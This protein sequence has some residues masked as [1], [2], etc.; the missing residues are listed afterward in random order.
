MERIT[1]ESWQCSGCNKKYPEVKPYAQTI[2]GVRYFRSLCKTC[3]NL[4]RLSYKKMKTTPEAAQRRSIQRKIETRSTNLEVRAAL[5]LKYCKSADKKKKRVSDL[6]V[7]FILAQISNP[8]F[9]CGDNLI[10][11]MTL[12]RIDNS[13]GHTKGNVVPACYRC[14]VTRGIMPYNAWLVV[15]EGM[16]KAN[17]LG[18]F[19]DWDGRTSQ[20]RWR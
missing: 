8:C 4:R 14:N 10:T 17:A 11:N 15:C 2:K 6:D 5:I 13:K 3:D 20:T 1:L 7:K 18:L 12:D 16:R 9:Y 19:G